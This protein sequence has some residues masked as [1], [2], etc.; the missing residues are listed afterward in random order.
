MLHERN[1]DFS[2]GDKVNWHRS[3]SAGYGSFTSVAGIVI[4]KNPKTC[5]ILV[6]HKAIHEWEL[7][8]RVVPVSSLT[9]RE[10]HAPQLDDADITPF[11]VV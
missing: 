6:A 3:T 5:T 2:P 4:K 11:L 9:R 10:R 1:T 8:K 7:I